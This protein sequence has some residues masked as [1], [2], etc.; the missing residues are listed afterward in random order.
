MATVTITLTDSD[1][2]VGIKVESD[3]PFD[4]SAEGT[5]AQGAAIAALEAINALLTEDAPGGGE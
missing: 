2:A 3:P 5:W 4:T 1:G